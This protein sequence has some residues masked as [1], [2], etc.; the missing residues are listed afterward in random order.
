MR[1]TVELR[2]RSDGILNINDIYN[3]NVYAIN[4]HELIGSLG[5]RGKFRNKP[6][7]YSLIKLKY[8]GDDFNESII[9]ACEIKNKSG[10]NINGCPI[11]YA[12]I[13]AF[14]ANDMAS[15]EFECEIISA[16]NNAKIPISIDFYVE[17]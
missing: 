10:S 7:D 6:I 15:F 16:L 1:F 14:H 8:M 4:K 5:V 11:E 12:I 9:D 17:K 3:S 2:V 13:I